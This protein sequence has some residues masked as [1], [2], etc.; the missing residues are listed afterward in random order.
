MAILPAASTTIDDEAGALAGGTGYAVVVGCVQDNDDI[1]PR[2]FTSTASLIDQHGYSPAVDYC[3]LHFEASKK[4]VLFV[5]L[6]KT[7]VGVAGSH[8][9]TGVTGTCNITVAAGSDGYLEEIDGVI[10]VVDG[11]TVGTTGI[12][13]NI[14]LDGGRTEKLVRLLTATTYTIPYVGVVV[15]FQTGGTLIAADVYTFRTTAPMWASADLASAK[16]ALAAQLKLARSFVVVGDIPNS[17]FAGYVTTALNGYETANDRFAYARVNVKDRLPLATKSKVK[18]TMTGLPSLT[19]AEVG[20]TGDTITRATGSWVTDG[21]VINDRITVAGT[22]SNNFTDALVTGVAATVLTLDTQD[23]V[24][25]VIATATLVGSETIT[26]AEVGATGDTITRSTGSWTADGFAVGDIV[27]VTG[28]A[29]NN[30]T[31]DAITALSATVM[32]LDTTD[33]AA[34]AIA[35]HRVSVVKVL[36]KAAWVSAQDTA[37]ASVDAQKRIDLG[38]G[39]LRKLSPITLWEFRRPT[40]WAASI[41]EYQHDLHIPCWAK[42][43]GPLDGWSMLDDDGNVTEFDERT[44]GGGLAAR[45]TCARTWANGPNGSFIAMSLTRATEGSILSRTHNMSVANLACTVVQASTENIIGKVLRLNADG[46]ATSASLTVIEEAINAELRIALL[47]PGTEGPRASSAVWRASTTDD[48]SVVGATLTGVLD[49][50]L[51]GTVEQVATTVKI[52]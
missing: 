33:L 38:L 22:A 14:S 11:G 28:T 3:A 40:A 52:S 9:S 4:P 1:T 12:T 17:T 35:G 30:V 37:F 51:N 41:R 46:T 21:F 13:F 26:F 15:S 20:A 8:N 25:E 7:T 27:A 34:E 31:T 10:T 5:G 47:Q 23:L 39:R 18:K 43:Q 48:L 44:D 45:F 24:A 32:T 2:V 36:T 29:S 6:P 19:F 42:E 49:L 16:T 50:R